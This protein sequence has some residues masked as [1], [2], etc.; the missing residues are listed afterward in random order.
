[1]YHL[2][3][4]PMVDRLVLL[5]YTVYTGRHYPS[6]SLARNRNSFGTYLYQVLLPALSARDVSDLALG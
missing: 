5:F 4:A 1:M 6:H 2:H 3:S